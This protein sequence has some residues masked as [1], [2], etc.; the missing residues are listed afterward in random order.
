[1]NTNYSID[2]ISVTMGQEDV[3]I[4]K[5]VAT[6]ELTIKRG[7]MGYSQQIEY[8]CGARYLWDERR[9]DRHMIYSGE[10]LRR[11]SSEICSF[12]I[13]KFHIENGHKIARIDI[14]IDVF[15]SGATV[16]EFSDLWAKNRVITR[17]RAGTLIADPR[18]ENGDTFYLG[19]RKRKRKLLRIYDKGKEQGT[20]MDWLRF[21]MQYNGGSARS[22]ARAIYSATDI[23][24]V[25][26]GQLSA[27]AKFS[28]QTFHD[29]MKDTSDSPVHHEIPYKPD[30]REYWIEKTV[31]PAL[32]KHEAIHPGTMQRIFKSVMVHVDQKTR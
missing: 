17:A 19:S 1:M 7:M 23:P 16:Q 21:E 2:W 11:L 6:P 12:D 8:P 27:Y 24:A 18:G 14:A 26:R 13:L 4:P 20:D 15:D 29:L 10:T 9:E 5:Q 30:S 31:I 28:H 22:A 25:M 3:H 32:R